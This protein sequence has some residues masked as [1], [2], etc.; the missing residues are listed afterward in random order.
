MNT[1]TYCGGQFIID[2]QFIVLKGALRCD[3]VNVE[4]HGQSYLRMRPKAFDIV[5]CN[6]F[7]KY[8]KL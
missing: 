4:G 7:L 1:N 5:C 8:F 3:D 2:A 6:V